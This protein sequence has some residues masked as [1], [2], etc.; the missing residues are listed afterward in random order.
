M[1]QSPLVFIKPIS[2][3]SDDFVRKKWKQNS[4][5]CLLLSLAFKQKLND[6]V[7]LKFDISQLMDG[8]WRKMYCF[9]SKKAEQSKILPWSSRRK[10]IIS[11]L[12]KWCVDVIY[13]W[14]ETLK[15]QNLTE[16]IMFML[17]RKTIILMSLCVSYRDWLLIS[18]YSIIKN[19][20][21]K[22]FSISN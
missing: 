2:G 5:G 12:D 18:S 10:V 21:V 6:K 20:T 7:Y 14:P 8:C 3:S 1:L 22:Y 19:I 4:R 15:L 11:L 17:R 13:S 16:T 9:S